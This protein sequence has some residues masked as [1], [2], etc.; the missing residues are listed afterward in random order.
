VR[1]SIDALICQPHFWIVVIEAKR[2]EYSLKVGI[3]K[4]LVICWLILFQKSLL[5]DLLQMVLSLFSTS[6]LDRIHPDMDFKH[7]FSL[8]N[9]GNSLYPL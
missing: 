5:L 9:R 3:P 8:L 2:A 1:V 6:S 4:A 7:E